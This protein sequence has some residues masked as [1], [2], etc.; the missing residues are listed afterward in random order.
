MLNF[1]GA[2]QGFLYSVK[3]AVLYP[4]RAVTAAF[5]SV[6]ARVQAAWAALTS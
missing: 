3:N 4:F 1:L 2:L 6:R 5:Q